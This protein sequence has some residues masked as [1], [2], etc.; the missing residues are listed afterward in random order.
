MMQTPWGMA[1]TVRR[2]DPESHIVQVATAS[3]GGLG[4]LACQSMPA[5]LRDI[6]TLVDS[7]T[8]FE[9]D[10]A[11]AAAVIAFPA[12][13]TS[14]V[15]EAA[16]QTMRDWYPGAYTTHYGE[17]LTAATSQT[18]AKREWEAATKDNFVVTTSFSDTFW[19]VP[20]GHVYACGFRAR[21]ERTAGFLVPVEE[22][23]SPQRLVLDGFPQWQPDRRLPYVK[24]AAA[25]RAC[26][27]A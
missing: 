16:K 22:Y 17:P 9:E 27:L 15:V 8:W 21:D 12:L 6:G 13:F 19:D 20:T 5:H 11:W 3:H 25:V 2:H 26:E 1:Q 10:T 7:R 23:V 14:E 4:V 18:I 24:P